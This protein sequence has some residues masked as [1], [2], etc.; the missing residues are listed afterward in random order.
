MDDSLCRLYAAG[1]IS[2]DTALTYC[3]RYDSTRRKLEAL[4]RL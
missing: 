2:Q 1:R 3:L 4:A